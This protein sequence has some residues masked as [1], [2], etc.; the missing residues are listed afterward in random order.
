MNYSS[1]ISLLLNNSSQ[2]LFPPKRRKSK[3]PT[4]VS[5]IQ[6]SVSLNLTTQGT[7]QGTFDQVSWTLDE[8]YGS[9]QLPGRGSQAVAC[10]LAPGSPALSSHHSPSSQSSEHS[11]SIPHQGSHSYFFS[12][13]CSLDLTLS[14]DSG[15]AVICSEGLYFLP[16]WS[17]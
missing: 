11:D 16:T 5:K 14:C 2:L 3:L 17:K 4:R 9:L 12:L 7:P 6:T 15:S 8:V 13:Q 1:L 10:D